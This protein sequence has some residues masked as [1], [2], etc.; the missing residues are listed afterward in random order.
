[1]TAPYTLA[2]LRAELPERGDLGET[3]RPGD[4]VKLMFDSE[5]GSESMWVKVTGARAAGYTGVLDNVPCFVPLGPGDLVEFTDNN[6]IR[7]MPA[8][9]AS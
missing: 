9:A 4:H 7:V 5:D 2:D 3:I 1:M 8:G 6:V